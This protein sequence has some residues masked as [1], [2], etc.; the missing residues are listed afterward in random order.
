MQKIGTLFPLL[1]SL[2]AVSHTN[3][4]LECLHAIFKKLSGTGRNSISRV[5]RLLHEFKVGNIAAIHSEDYNRTR[6]DVLQKHNLL[7][8][9]FEEIQLFASDKEWYSENILEIALALHSPE[10]N[11]LV[12]PDYIPSSE[13]FTLACK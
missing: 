4:M 6:K 8:Q 11:I 2:T 12:Y 10:E 1:L 7:R 5:S 3:N 9:R 13:K